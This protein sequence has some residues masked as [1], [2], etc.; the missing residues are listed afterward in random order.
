MGFPAYSRDYCFRDNLGRP[1]R[2]TAAHLFM[3]R[4][5]RKFRELFKSF[6]IELV[7]YALLVVGYFFAVLHFLG[8]WLDHLF[9]HDR[10]TYAFMSLILIIG[11]GLL[12]EAVT[13][14]LLRFIKPEAEAPDRKGAE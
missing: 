10:K 3:P 13:R 2:S 7:V 12:L 6:I 9:R 8:G 1:E 11:Q 4:I 5:K 14:G